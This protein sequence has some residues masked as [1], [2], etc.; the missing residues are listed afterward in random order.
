[1]VRHVELPKMTIQELKS[2]LRYQADLHIPFNLDEA[3]YD[4]HILEDKENLPENKMRVIIVAIKRKDAEEVVDIITKAGY[5]IDLLSVDSVALF[6]AFN[7]GLTDNEKS[8]IIALVDIGASKTNINIIDKGESALCREIK[9]GGI[10]FT[11]MLIEGFNIGF[12]EAEQKKLAGDDAILSFAG[13]AYKPIVRDIRASFDYF[14]G[15]MGTSIQKL[16]LSGGGSL[17]RGITDYLKEKLGIPVVIWNPIRK[18]DDSSLE[19]KD[20]LIGNSP[21]LT[22]CMGTAMS[23]L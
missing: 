6:N 3:Y 12:D 4:A 5:S 17:A 14:E 1:I 9:Y 22:V 21:L 20:F 13:E 15:M 7:Y 11:E 10:K 2:S 8:E 19:D 23:P 18:V 16:Y